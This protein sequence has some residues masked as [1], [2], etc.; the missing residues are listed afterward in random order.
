MRIY[1]FMYVSARARTNAHFCVRPRRPQPRS[2]C[3]GLR[4]CRRTR[5]SGSPP[6]R[7]LCAVCM[8]ARLTPAR[9]RPS[10]FPSTGLLRCLSQS[11]VPRCSMVVCLLRLRLLARRPRR[12]PLDHGGVEA[13]HDAVVFVNLPQRGLCCTGGDLP[14]WMAQG[15]F[16]ACS[17]L[18]QR[19]AGTCS[20]VHCLTAPRDSKRFGGMRR[21]REARLN[22]ANVVK[23]AQCR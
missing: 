8:R 9:A 18:V 17:S 5:T 4:W 19:P 21:R 20:Q 23:V 7:T 13:P 22:H 15:L 3:W 11:A 16:K 14:R 2:R 12:W 6:A 10:C 1:L